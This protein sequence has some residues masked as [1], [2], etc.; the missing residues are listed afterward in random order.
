[1]RK[2]PLTDY[3]D[4]IKLCNL[5]E[6]QRPFLKRIHKPYLARWLLGLNEMISEW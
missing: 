2:K 4:L 1:M 6:L 5:A 3:V